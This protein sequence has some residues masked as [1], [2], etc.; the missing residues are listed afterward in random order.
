MTVWAPSPIVGYPTHRN[1]IGPL[2]R[3]DGPAC[4]ASTRGLYLLVGCDWEDVPDEYR[5]SSCSPSR[6]P[7]QVGT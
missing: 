6:A 7:A 2:G 5:C 3:N 4:G 1:V